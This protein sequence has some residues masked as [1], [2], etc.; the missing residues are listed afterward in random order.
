MQSAGACSTTTY[1]RRPADR[2]VILFPFENGMSYH[3]TARDGAW[4]GLGAI[5][6]QGAVRCIDRARS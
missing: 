4:N 1:R 3:R 2:Q 6:S 5:G